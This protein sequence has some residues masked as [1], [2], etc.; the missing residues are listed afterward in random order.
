MILY[1]QY[2]KH[3]NPARRKELDYCT[4]VNI[5]S[6]IFEKVVIFLEKEEDDMEWLHT[7]KT[8]VVN[9][10][11]RLSY[12][13]CFEYSNKYPDS[14]HVLCNL[15][16]FFDSTGSLLS[17]I[18][19]GQFIALTRWDVDMSTK[20][21]KLFNTNCSQD[22]WVW[23]GTV[24]LSKID[25][26]YTLGTGGCDNAICGEFHENGYKVLNPALSVRTLHLHTEQARTYSDSIGKNLY[27]LWP[28]NSFEDTRI[29]FWKK[30]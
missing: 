10:N 18:K 1:I 17:S 6:R 20:K 4:R 25:G 26:S 3:N 22:T 8:D 12:R 11:K 19:D 9:I 24:D 28:N 30:G 7:E 16:I 15:D 29:Q 21:S 23:K 2:F 27:F 14:I 13:D 5:K